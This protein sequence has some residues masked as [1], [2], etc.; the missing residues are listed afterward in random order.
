VNDAK[1][2]AAEALRNVTKSTHLPRPLGWM[3]N[4][5]VVS[6]TVVHHTEEAGWAQP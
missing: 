5:V 3:T 1:A 2:V 6:S 4:G